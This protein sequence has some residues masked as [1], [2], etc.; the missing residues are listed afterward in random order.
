MR[1][2][3]WLMCLLVACGA[4]LQGCAGA[5]DKAVSGLS[6]REAESLNARHARFESAEDPP[7][8][9]ETHY[10]AG[11]LAESHNQL[12][13]AVEQYRAALRVDGGHLPSLFRLGVIHSTRG[14]HARAVEV[15][16][17]YAR[18]TNDDPTACANLGL[19]YEMA[20]QAAQAEAAYKRG[21]ARDPTNH[22]CRVN[23]GLMLARAGRIAEATAQ[24]QTVLTPPQVHYNLAAAHEEMG[25][26][27]EARAE[28]RRA[29][30]LDPSF[31][32]ARI[33]LAAIGD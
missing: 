33:R 1:R 21:M 17:T 30:E 14:E 3:L 5:D 7:F 19:S 4:A 24:L 20:G 15:W 2:R 16:K 13:K 29:V 31:E 6:R 12:D 8:T 11:R 22:A 18:R 32:D 25:R 28:Y 23:Y 27:A 26:K 9:A 10:A